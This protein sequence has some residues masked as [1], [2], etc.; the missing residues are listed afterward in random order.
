M[1]HEPVTLVLEANS[2]AEEQKRKAIAFRELTPKEKAR[3]QGDVEMITVFISC[4]C[5]SGCNSSMLT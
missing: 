5:Y 2:E 3:G 1:I 4:S